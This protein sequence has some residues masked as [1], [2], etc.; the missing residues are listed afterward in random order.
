MK[1][2]ESEIM[3]K[4]LRYSP[5]ISWQ[6]LNDKIYIIN[7]DTLDS[8]FLEDVSMRMWALIGRGLSVGE[9]LKTIGREYDVD[10][11]TLKSDIFE[12]IQELLENDIVLYEN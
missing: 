9:I 2:N 6:V 11:C 12:L 8:F 7:E 3:L 10:M 4:N 5:N 1:L